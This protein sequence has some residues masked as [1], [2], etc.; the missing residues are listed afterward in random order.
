MGDV[1]YEDRPL[2]N[3]LLDAKVAATLATTGDLLTS[4]LC[5]N[6]IVILITS[7]KDDG[8]GS[9]KATSNV[10]STALTFA[11]VNIL[12]IIYKIPIHVIAVKPLAGDVAQLTEYRDE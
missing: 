11:N 12:G 1:G 4:R 3:A 9:Y 8:T 2:T 7:G 5:R 6:T 10:E